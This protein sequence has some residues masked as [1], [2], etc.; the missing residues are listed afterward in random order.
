[1][2]LFF[3]GDDVDLRSYRSRYYLP[4]A[5]WGN[6]ADVEHW[7]VGS[8]CSKYYPFINIYYFVLRRQNP[9]AGK[10]PVIISL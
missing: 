1:M 5:G 3:S 9:D 10:H 4:D 7:N 6:G 8:G 2:F